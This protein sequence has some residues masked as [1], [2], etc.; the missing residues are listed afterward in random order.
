M[1][2][3]VGIYGSGSSCNKP[4]SAAPSFALKCLILDKLEVWAIKA[5]SI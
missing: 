2:D 4:N 1:D 5:S 3:I